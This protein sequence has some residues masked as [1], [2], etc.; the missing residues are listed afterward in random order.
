MLLSTH[1][2]ILLG[3]LGALGTKGEMDQGLRLNVYLC[4]EIYVRSSGAQSPQSLQ[5]LEI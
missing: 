5:T 3:L 2:F 1:L 4:C